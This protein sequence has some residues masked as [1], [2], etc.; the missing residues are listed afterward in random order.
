MKAMMYRVNDKGNVVTGLI[1]ANHSEEASVNK[2][3]VAIAGTLL[4][5]TIGFIALMALVLTQ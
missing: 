2:V 1:P 3:G 5:L 4:L